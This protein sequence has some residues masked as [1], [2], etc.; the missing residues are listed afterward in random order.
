VLHHGL[1]PVVIEQRR[2][3]LTAAYAS[4][5]ARFVAGPPQPPDVPEEVWINKP[6]S[7]VN[8]LQ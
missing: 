6:Q 1:A 4:H 2:V 3:T 5:P 7:T 8:K